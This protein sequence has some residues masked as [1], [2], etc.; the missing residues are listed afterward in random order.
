MA[1]G[2][3]GK[4]LIYGTNRGKLDFSPDLTSGH[5]TEGNETVQ[6]RKLVRSSDRA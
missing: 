4:R 5:G 3:V 2:R 6:D 1:T